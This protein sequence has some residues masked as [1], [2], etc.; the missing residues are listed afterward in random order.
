M[1]SETSRQDNRYKTRKQQRETEATAT[2][3]GKLHNNAIQ[4]LTGEMERNQ[5]GSESQIIWLKDSREKVV[6]G[7][8]FGD[9]KLGLHESEDKHK[10][11][12]AP[13]YPNPSDEDSFYSGVDEPSAGD[14]SSPITT[15]TLAISQTSARS[16]ITMASSRLA[17]E[18]LKSSDTGSFACTVREVLRD[19]D[20]TG[21]GRENATSVHGVRDELNVGSNSGTL[22]VQDQP[23]DSMSEHRKKLLW[24]FN[25]NGIHI[26]R[27]QNDD[28]SNEMELVKEINGHS[29]VNSEVDGNWNQLTLCG[30]L[31]QEQ[32][33][34]CE[35]SDNAIYIEVPVLG[36]GS[37]SSK[38]ATRKY[39]YVGQPNLNR[40]LVIDGL[41]FE[42]VAI[43][44]T[45][46]QPRKIFPYKP[47]KIHLS[48]WVRRRLSPAANARWL[49]AI[50]THAYPLDETPA[51]SRLYSVKTASGSSR[52]RRSNWE[53]SESNRELRTSSDKLHLIQHDLWLL[54]YG[55]PLVLDPSG[56]EH[57][58]DI[59][60]LKSFDGSD[61]QPA[62]KTNR[63]RR[64]AVQPFQPRLSSGGGRPNSFGWPSLWPT[65]PNAKLSAHPSLV[66]INREA[67]LRNRKSIH[68]IQST[69]FPKVLANDITHGSH[70]HY[71]E[72]QQVSNQSNKIKNETNVAKFKKSTTITTH[73]VLSS[74]EPKSMESPAG[75]M[76]APSFP[77]LQ[78]QRRGM[79]NA[80]ISRHLTPGSGMETTKLRQQMAQQAPQIDL[81]QNLYIPMEPYPLTREVGP[82]GKESSSSKHKIH[83]AYISNYQEGRLRRVSMD[84]YRLDKD[85]ELE[86]CDPIDLVVTAQ[87]H[88]IVQCREP[89]MN[90]DGNLIGQLVLDQVTNSRVEFNANVRAHQAYLSP[91]HR[92]LISINNGNRIYANSGSNNETESESQE[93]SEQSIVY[94]QMVTI[95]GLRLQY[96][97]K[98]S[99]ELSQCSFVWKDGYYAAIIVSINRREKQSEILNLRL[100]D[101]RLELMSRVP[102]LTNWP[103]HREQF[104]VTPALRIATVSTNQGVF[105]VDLE[106]NR[107]SGSIINHRQTQ[108]PTLLWT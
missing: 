60:G 52:S 63:S 16:S 2:T 53:R 67:Q 79:R 21:N 92:Y 19:Y 94:V 82:V 104:L 98:T 12:S 100:A 48:K 33:V 37:E 86:N 20:D 11:H 44:N 47:N 108:P 50:G 99:L 10:S 46:P 58:D 101:G 34:I 41:E 54:C 24:M 106:D 69:F 5:F 78:N 65:S 76:F 17:I 45:E 18:N 103:A 85:I 68:I 66:M 36:G 88:L 28:G 91:D 9:S 81:I 22:L 35:W 27:L 83:Y 73:H 75:S 3:R 57:L 1:P 61:Q 23:P 32:A 14:S 38:Q 42:I 64:L 74:F 8:E 62:R 95:S 107:V 51:N 30:G 72:E 70:Q 105:I 84:N 89:S 90:I 97:I 6:D 31:N 87:G 55:Q 25:D 13:S 102:G 43:I 80:Y 49:D 4:M 96:E 40:V 77:M 26:Y 59:Y 39:V 71:N 7:K 93:R 56:D 15:N 29:Q